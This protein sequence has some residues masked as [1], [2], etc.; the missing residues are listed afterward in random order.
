MEKRNKLKRGSTCFSE[1]SLGNRALKFKNDVIVCR[2]KSAHQTVPPRESVGIVVVE[3]TMMLIM[4]NGTNHGEGSSGDPVCKIF[5]SSMT[6]DS[7]KLIIKLVEKQGD[8]MD[9]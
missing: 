3:M 4:E 6:S 1:T 7:G 9:G 2:M 5:V 8:G